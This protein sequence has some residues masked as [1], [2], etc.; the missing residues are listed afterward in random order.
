[1]N[2]T[3][4]RERLVGVTLNLPIFEGF[5][6]TYKVRGAD[7][8]VE[9]RAAELLDVEHR[10]AMEVVQAYSDAAA[11]LRNLEAS[12]TLLRTA[13][14]SLASSRRRYEK[15]PPMCLRFSASRKLWLMR[16]KSVFAACR[17]GARRACEWF[18]RR[19]SS[20]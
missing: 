1:M 6:R 2:S 14:S 18:L 12:D 10:V 13:Q 8:L 11:A 20:E 9:Q 17:S 3:P 7:A 4:T 5:A 19:A 16:N 15:E